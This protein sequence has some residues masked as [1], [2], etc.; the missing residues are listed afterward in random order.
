MERQEEMTILMTMER[1]DEEEIGKEITTATTNPETIAFAKTNGIDQGTNIE[2]AEEIA[3]AIATTRN[4]HHTEEIAL[5][6]RPGIEIM[7]EETEIT[8]E[9]TEKKT[10]NAKT[11]IEKTLEK[12]IDMKILTNLLVEG[13]EMGIAIIGLRVDETRLV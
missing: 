1:E 2:T 10:T 6:P 5:F 4:P 12:E 13:T 8:I 11:E 3:R 9:E 7:T